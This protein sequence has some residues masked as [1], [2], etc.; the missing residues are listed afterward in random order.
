MTD[1]ELIARADANYFTVWPLLCS[2]G[3]G[4]GEVIQRGGLTITDSGTPLAMVN[5]IFVTRPLHDPVAELRRA[6]AFLDERR[7]PFLVR[8]REGLDPAADRA[9]IELGL[10]EGGVTPGMALNQMTSEGT[11]LEGLTIVTAAMRET[12]LHHLEVV[13]EGFGL[14]RQFVELLRPIFPHARCRAL[15]GYVDDRPA[16]ASAPSSPPTMASTTSPLPE[17]WRRHREHDVAQRLARRAWGQR[18]TLPAPNGFPIYGAWASA[19]LAYHLSPAA[20][21]RSPAS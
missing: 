1:D 19:C 20:V 15:A 10:V 13:V 21:M 7:R 6:L 3:D 16:A 9:C 2:L 11:R 18:P 4:G 8:I 5:S 14:P 12:F 17:A